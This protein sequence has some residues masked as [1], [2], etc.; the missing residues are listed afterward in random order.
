MSNQDQNTDVGIDRDD[1]TT[2]SSSKSSVDKQLGQVIP[3]YNLD[4]MISS[5]FLSQTNF[6]E[7]IQY[8]QS[9]SSVITEND[10][11]RNIEKASSSKKEGSFTVFLLVSTVNIFEKDN[12][13]KTSKIQSA[14][15]NAKIAPGSIAT[16]DIVFKQMRRRYDQYGNIEILVPTV[17]ALSKKK[18]E[19][20]EKEKA[21]DGTNDQTKKTSNKRGRDDVSDGNPE[22]TRKTGPDTKVVAR[23]SST[24]IVV[25]TPGKSQ[26]VVS[27]S[28][29]FPPS[30]QPDDLSDTIMSDVMVD[31]SAK[32][33]LP[34]EIGGE[35]YK[36]KP[37]KVYTPLSINREMM[38]GTEE[39]IIF[40]EPFSIS[41]VEIVP[42][43]YIDKDD[44]Y[45][46][47]NWSISSVEYS[48]KIPPVKLYRLME[49]SCQKFF[50][51]TKIGEYFERTSKGPFV[52]EKEMMSY[53]F[54]KNNQ[55]WIV[56]GND[57]TYHRPFSAKNVASTERQAILQLVRSFDTSMFSKK[58]MKSPD[59][60]VGI[61]P[62]H[63]E[64]CQWSGVHSPK[65]PTLMKFLISFDIQWKHL[66]NTPVTNPTDCQ[67]GKTSVWE[68]GAGLG[69][70]NFDVWNNVIFCNYP[71]FKMIV[72]LTEDAG[73]G[74]KN[75]LNVDRYKTGLKENDLNFINK[76]FKSEEER[77]NMLAFKIQAVVLKAIFLPVQSIKSFAIPI[78]GEY[79]MSPFCWNV[80]NPAPTGSNKNPAA[81]PR[82]PPSYFQGV[83]PRN[84]TKEDAVSC[85]SEMKDCKPYLPK[86]LLNSEAMAFVGDIY[87][88][89]IA[90][91]K[92]N[93]YMGINVYTKHNGSAQMTKIISSL[94]PHEG[95]I[96]IE[97]IKHIIASK[98]GNKTSFSSTSKPI[99]ER[100]Y[101][102]TNNASNDEQW[103]NMLTHFKVPKKSSLWTIKFSD[104]L[105]G[106]T[107]PTEL[108]SVIWGIPLDSDDTEL[109][110]N[111]KFIYEFL[112]P[113]L[114]SQSNSQDELA[115]VDPRIFD[116]SDSKMFEKFP[117]LAG[118]QEQTANSSSSDDIYVGP[119][120]SCIDDDKIDEHPPTN[121][122]PQKQ[123][124]DRNSIY[125]DE[126]DGI[127]NQ[128][129]SEE[130][131]LTKGRKNDQ[132][133]NED[134]SS[135]KLMDTNEGLDENGGEPVSP[136]QPVVDDDF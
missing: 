106:G 44:S 22:K 123:I 16:E 104:L 96:L 90:P 3:D 133:T 51:Q 84:P 23:P 83:V 117:L 76:P 59:K 61:L 47:N 85:L 43:A 39:G 80:C 68:G 82:R 34:E 105:I 41:K 58:T 66:S 71:S 27:D 19:A 17:C 99:N 115:G 40:P 102:P 15:V 136:N 116:S 29:V 11:K 52:D 126:N 28:D 30:T 31:D 18:Q 42:N 79:I 108:V 91:S 48:V 69:V 119:K 38:F 103:S 6:L 8:H 122:Q 62:Y 60:P 2:T 24:A 37:I 49:E 92:F 53:K 50:Y 109:E 33:Y 132:D 107:S 93:F 78:S 86:D 110:P 55:F 25:N 88:Y 135:D 67:K 98:G 97:G 13:Q 94:G 32:V 124:R 81:P 130:F 95:P 131:P 20:K 134:V 101:N 12:I 64:C 72:Q 10:I 5:A 1:E 118:K 89:K 35:K 63:L 9:D 125:D 100:I 75:V 65:N 7:T 73:F 21:Q 57:L 46:V 87:N 127:N 111:K 112:V 128:Q 54:N 114:T 121:Y 113:K 120:V 77:N 26:L 74:S 45:K 129:I 70:T 36:D 4:D 56:V 14:L